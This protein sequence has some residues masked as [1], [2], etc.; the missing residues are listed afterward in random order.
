MYWLRS[1]FKTWTEKQG[2]ELMPEDLKFIESILIKLPESRHKQ[3]MRD[4]SQKWLDGIESSKS[5][6]SAQNLGRR[7]ANSWLRK[8]L[9]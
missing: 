8:Q 7:M 3:L 9:D 6:Q 2:I 1:K 5:V 4:Y